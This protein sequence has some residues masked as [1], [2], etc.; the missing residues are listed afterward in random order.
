MQCSYLLSSYA[1]LSSL[2][3]LQ[4]ANAR[5]LGC[6]WCARWLHSQCG[7]LS[8]E[9]KEGRTLTDSRGDLHKKIDT[10]RATHHLSSCSSFFL[11]GADQLRVEVLTGCCCDMRRNKTTD[12][13]PSWLVQVVNEYSTN[14]F[15]LIAMAAGSLP[16]VHQLDLAHM[17]QQAIE[18]AAVDMEMLGL[19]VLANSMRDD[20][21]TTIKQLQEE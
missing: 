16:E 4:Y 7:G 5:K 13:T 17:S 21:V 1:S 12:Q 8:R 6:S 2:A 3:F 18:A 14:S 9:R 10:N 19:V 11:V 20:S 15:R